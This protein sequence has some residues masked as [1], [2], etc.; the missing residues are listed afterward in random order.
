MQAT[1]PVWGE[2]LVERAWARMLR[3]KLAYER[4]R[5]ACGF[6]SPEYYQNRW[7]LMSP[8]GW[9]EKRPPER[10]ETS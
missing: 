6:T 8:P 2:S 1:E 9:P 4:M 10:Q 7:A 5:L 3:E